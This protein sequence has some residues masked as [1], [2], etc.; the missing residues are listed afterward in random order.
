MSEFVVDVKSHFLK[1]LPLYPS[2][3]CRTIYPRTS[4]NIN[5][6]VQFCQLGHARVSVTAPQW[7]TMEFGVVGVGLLFN[8]QSS[9]WRYFYPNGNFFPCRMTSGERRRVPSGCL[10]SKV[11]NKV[12]TIHTVSFVLQVVLIIL[13]IKR[14][15][16]SFMIA[17][18]GIYSCQKAHANNSTL[19]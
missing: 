18:Y 17:S 6:S 12:S 1:R 2:S 8:K 9:H 3:N 7:L 11:I 14:F 13:R 4:L 19:W 16:R 5:I 15:F 10:K